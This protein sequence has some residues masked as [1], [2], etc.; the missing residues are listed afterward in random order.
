MNPDLLGIGIVLGMFLALMT[1]LAWWQKK[2]PLHPELFRK[3]LHMGMG[4]VSLTFPWLFDSAWPVILLALTATGVLVSI[5]HIKPLSR[6]F[7]SVVGGV[8]RI[9]RGEFYFPL[10]VALVFLYSGGQPFFYCIPIL[11]LTA[12][13]TG[14]AL[15]GIRFGRHPYATIDGIKSV[16]GSIV[17]FLITF[18]II[19]PAL[20]IFGTVEFERHFIWTALILSG[21]LTMLEGVSW[22]G[23]DN[24]FVP[25]GTFTLLQRYL[26][27]E[28]SEVIFRA[29][30]LAVIASIII[31]RHRKTTLVGNA[32]MVCILV[33]YTSWMLADWRWF[34]PPLVYY[35]SY[36]RLWP[37]KNEEVH[38]MHAVGCVTLPPLFW[39]VLS[40]SLPETEAMFSYF[41]TYGTNLAVAGDGRYCQANPE[42]SFLKRVK[43][44]VPLSWAIFFLPYFVLSGYIGL[45]LWQVLFAPL[46]MA[47]ALWINRY[48]VK[49]MCKNNLS[50]KDRR[51]VRAVIVFFLSTAGL[52][53]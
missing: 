31:V 39:L 9:S 28:P 49:E 51:V 6:R 41:F 30:F 42:L 22:R 12:A 5:K 24:L 43:K 10:S 21:L 46:L 33:A 36:F 8:N 52:V 14:A 26:V 11:V 18:V 34:V 15:A 1:L 32:P 38:N 19:L 50:D 25:L 45:A 29:T 7:Y 23:L 53:F 2:D 20:F 35:L 40:Q 3:T 17:F 13:D 16:E 4:V 47:S 37:A 44:T 27:L 48:Y